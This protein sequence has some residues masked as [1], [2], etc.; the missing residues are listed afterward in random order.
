MK[1]AK[2]MFKHAHGPL[3]EMVP[4]IFTLAH[5]TSSSASCVTPLNPYQSQHVTWCFKTSHNKTRDIESWD[6]IPSLM[7]SKFYSVM[8][9]CGC[10]QFVIS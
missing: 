1:F 6:E 8:C 9:T 7:N 5:F 4:L 3:D 10:A 2:N